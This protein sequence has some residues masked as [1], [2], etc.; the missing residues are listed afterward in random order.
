LCG[1][2][3]AVVADRLERYVREELPSAAEIKLVAMGSRLAGLFQRRGL[4]PDSS[5]KLSLTKLPPYALTLDMT[6]RWL[7]RTQAGTSVRVIIVYNQYRA[8]HYQPTVIQLIPAV[9]VSAQRAGRQPGDQEAPWPPAI[10]ETDPAHLRARVTEQW[11][12]IQFYRALLASATAEHA[13]RYQLMEGATR[14]AD[15]LITELT[16]AV[17]TARQQ[18]ITREMQELAAGAGLIGSK[19]PSLAYFSEG[20]DTNRMSSDAAVT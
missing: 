17:Q 12:A 16:L 14:N 4:P 11:T 19:Q 1:R 20:P 15:R 18:A 10:L 7:A 3:N 13:A 6:R 8:M 5:H 2:F 9:E